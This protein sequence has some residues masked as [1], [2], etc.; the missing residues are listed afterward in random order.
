MDFLLA[1][2]GSIVEGVSDSVLLQMRRQEDLVNLLQTNVGC[3]GVCENRVSLTVGL[4]AKETRLTEKVNNR[5][6]CRE[7]NGKDDVCVE[8]DSRDENGCW[9]R[10]DLV[11]MSSASAVAYRS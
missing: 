3:L 6:E 11:W 5:N 9:W 1:R 8:T 2:V 4:G 7:Q 10:L